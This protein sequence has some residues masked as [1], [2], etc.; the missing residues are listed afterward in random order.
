VL[1]DERLK[2]GKLFGKDYFDRISI[3]S[4]Q[5]R[6]LEKLQDIL[7]PKLMSGEV[8]VKSAKGEAAI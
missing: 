8:P 3:N 1:D 5:I 7:L 4:S 6:T 2:Q